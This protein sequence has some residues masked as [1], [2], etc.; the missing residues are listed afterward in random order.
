MSV[1]EVRFLVSAFER[2]QSPCSLKQRQVPGRHR[3]LQSEYPVV[4]RCHGRLLRVRLRTKWDLGPLFL[5][6][7]MELMAVAF[8]GGFR[9]TVVEVA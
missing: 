4:G 8:R 5:F 7:E 1:H 3:D 9:R 2:S 6:L